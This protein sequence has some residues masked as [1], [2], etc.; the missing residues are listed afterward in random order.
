LA[1]S[2]RYPKTKTW[3]KSLQ[4]LAS[5]RKLDPFLETVTELDSLCFRWSVFVHPK[6]AHAMGNYALFLQFVHQSFDN[7]DKMY[8]RAIAMDSSNDLVIENYMRMQQEL[9]PHGLYA[10]AGPSREAIRRSTVSLSVCLT[11]AVNYSQLLYYVDGKRYRW[12]MEGNGR[13]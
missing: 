6:N 10:F 7:A 4:L 13:F 8:R 2:C 3:K 9:G 5:A 11:V 1:Y 12:W